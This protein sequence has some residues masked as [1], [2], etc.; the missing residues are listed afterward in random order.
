MSEQSSAMGK[1]EGAMN[2]AYDTL[3]VLRKKRAALAKELVRMDAAI[4]CQ[5]VNVEYWRQALW[6]AAGPGALGEYALRDWDEY[7]RSHPVV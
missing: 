7:E 2:D 4:T 6:Q 5:R 1:T 3:D